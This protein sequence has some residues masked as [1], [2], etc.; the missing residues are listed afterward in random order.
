[1]TQWQVIMGLEIL[2]WIRNQGIS[3]EMVFETLKRPEQIN[4]AHIG[5][6]DINQTEGTLRQNGD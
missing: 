6:T 2:L 4:H 5:R 1:M 3:T